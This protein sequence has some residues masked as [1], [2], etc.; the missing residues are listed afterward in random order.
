M[1]K[2]SAVLALLIA[3]S[4]P[5]TAQEYLS[6]GRHNGPYGN[7]GNPYSQRGGGIAPMF[8]T[9]DGKQ[10]S[11]VTPQPVRPLPATPIWAP[12]QTQTDTGHSLQYQQYQQSQPSPPPPP[13][14]PPVEQ[15]QPYPAQ[16]AE[17]AQPDLRT[18]A[19]STLEE[20]E[21]ILDYQPTSTGPVDYLSWYLNGAQVDPAQ[22][23]KAGTEW[24]E[25]AVRHFIA[26]YLVAF[27]NVTMQDAVLRILAPL[28]LAAMLVKVGSMAIDRLLSPDSAIS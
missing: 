2:F 7:G 10:P 11:L 18:M 4:S 3:V 14:S 27:W 19:K 8:R 5:A 17:P 26:D 6:N 28:I 21:Q 23:L 24:P 25:D 22:F 13:V 12:S 15:Q 16:P 20:I 9:E 1:K